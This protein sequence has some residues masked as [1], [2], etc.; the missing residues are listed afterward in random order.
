VAGA[1]AGA[2]AASSFLPQAVSATAIMEAIRND[3]F[4]GNL[5]E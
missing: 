5:P 2:G 4:M 1:G 3:L